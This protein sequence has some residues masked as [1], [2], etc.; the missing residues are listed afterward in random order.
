MQLVIDYQHKPATT[1][2]L[3]AERFGKDH[4]NVLRDIENLECSTNFWRLNFE[5]SN[6]E[7]RGKSYP[8]YIMTRDGFTFLVM[9]F[10][11]LSAANFK[12]EYIEQFNKMETVIRS[13]T[14]QLIP[15]YQE[16]ILSEPTLNVP[17]GYW[18]VFDR[19]HKIML[20]VEKH[21]GSINK[22][23]IVDGSI[24]RNWS[25]FRSKQEWASTT[26]TYIHEFCDN[27]GGV[28]CKCYH[29]SEQD[30]FDDW[31]I[32]VYK[33]AHLHKYLVSKYSGEKN[34]FMLDRVN[35]ILP[36]LLKAPNR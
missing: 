22:Y 5:L 17:K 30:Y 2:L 27:R 10:T 26:E 8:M 28:E 1:S 31:L 19:S 25:L 24:G 33:P 7:S 14:P 16:R 32:D 34:Q 3:V 36:Q 15:I 13:T 9:G 21:I 20:F 6:Y 35:K 23:D 11:G 18:S 12:E 4:K 29:K